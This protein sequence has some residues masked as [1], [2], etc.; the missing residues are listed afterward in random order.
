LGDLTRSLREVLNGAATALA[1]GTDGGS[2]ALLTVEMEQLRL[3]GT[4]QAD[5]VL[6]NTQAVLQNTVAQ[7]TSSVSSEARSAGN[8]ALGIA[9]AGLSPLI[10][11]VVSLFTRDREQEAEPLTSYTR[12]ASVSVEGLVQEGGGVSWRWP[13]ELQRSSSARA[14]A[15]APQITVQVQALDSRSFLDRKD[16]IARAVREAVLHSHS[17]V[18]VWG[19]M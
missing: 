4:R 2:A 9:T 11:G 18:D 12:P 16:D 5:A 14:A 17:L 6:E 1:R 19:E 15:A 10:R 8:L 13:E 3:T 7:A